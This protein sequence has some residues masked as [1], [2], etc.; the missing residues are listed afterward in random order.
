MGWIHMPPPLEDVWIKMIS[1]DSFG[2]SFEV[3][4]EGAAQT[5]ENVQKYQ[6]DLNRYVEQEVTAAAAAASMSEA[7]MP[8]PL[9]AERPVMPQYPP[10]MQADQVAHSRPLVARPDNVADGE[11]IEDAEL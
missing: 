1:T 9:S 5:E 4:V 11:D 6:Q 10:P 7:G 8:P 3:G 2:M